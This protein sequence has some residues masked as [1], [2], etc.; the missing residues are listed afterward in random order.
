MAVKFNKEMLL[1]HRFWVLVSVTACLTLGGIFYLQLYG[2][3]ETGK[4]TK[5]FKTAAKEGAT[6]VG[7]T[8]AAVIAKLAEFEERAR[9]SESIIW[10]A[11]YKEQ[12]D[13]FRW[14]PKM[15]ATFEFLNGKFAHD[16]KIGK[17]ADEKSW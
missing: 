8:N 13:M 11:A 4:A 12:A 1:K 3:E 9:K 15:E 10:S 2:G 17:I 6:T 7:K 14:A 16:I 5:A